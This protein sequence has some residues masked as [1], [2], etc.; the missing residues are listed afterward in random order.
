MTTGARKLNV[1]GY[2]AA[3]N[4]GGGNDSHIAIYNDGTTSN[5]ASTYTSSGSYLPMAFQ[6][7]GTERMRIN[8]TG[9]IGVGQDANG[10]AQLQVKFDAT[11]SANNFLGIGIS[12]AANTSNA[13]FMRFYNATGNACGDI[14]RN[15]TSNAVL[16]NTSSDYRLKDSIT[17]MVGALAK[18]QALKPVTWTW[19][20]GGQ[21]GEGFIAH[22]VQELVPSAVSGE[23]DAVDTNGKP[24]YQGMDASYLVATLT[25]AIQEQQT[26]INDLKARIETLESK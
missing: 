26:I 10:F 14:T 18:V 13:V 3:F 1:Q 16:Y 23:K 19:K 17:P 11:T 6:T 25:A 15:G 5:I 24:V 8:S 2:I 12:P 9:V 7:G 4:T 22:E 21:A 20:D